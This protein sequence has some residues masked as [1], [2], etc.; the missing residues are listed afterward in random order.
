MFE[1][2]NGW[3]FENKTDCLNF[4]DNFGQISNYKECSSDGDNCEISSLSQSSECCPCCPPVW[5]EFLCWPPAP[6][7]SVVK[8]LCPGNFPQLHYKSK[9]L[10]ILISIF[11]IRLVN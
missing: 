1:V 11:P 10:I 4:L 8:Q 5:D 3:D 6:V 2:R 9:N 7:N